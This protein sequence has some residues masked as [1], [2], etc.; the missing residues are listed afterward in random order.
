MVPTH[1]MLAKQATK[2]ADL[3]PCR[4]FFNAAS[5]QSQPSSSVQPSDTRTPHIVLCA[6]FGWIWAA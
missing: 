2:L 1:A 6:G 5:L 3:K 4:R